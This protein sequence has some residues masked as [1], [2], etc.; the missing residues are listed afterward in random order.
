M[1]N[2]YEEEPELPAWPGAW[3]APGIL[4]GQAPGQARLFEFQPGLIRP[5][6]L[7]L[8]HQARPGLSWWPARQ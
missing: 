8:I 7:D 2:S 4:A 1:W 5:F 3:Q 6:E